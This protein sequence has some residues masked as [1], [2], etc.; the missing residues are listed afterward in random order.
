MTSFEDY[1]PYDSY[2]PNQRR[3]L[4]EAHSVIKGGDH[5]VLMVEA[6]TGTG[7]T[8]ILCSAL[9]AS[10]KTIVVVRTVSQINIY[11]EEM[12]RIHGTGHTLTMGYVV[13]KAKACPLAGEEP[14]TLDMCRRL[15][16]K[17][18]KRMENHL[19][20]GRDPSIEN[21]GMGKAL[22]GLEGLPGEEPGQRTYC[23]YY[24]R[25]IKGVLSGGE[26]A[27]EPSTLA[28]RGA[29]KILEELPNP[30]TLEEALG[31]ACPYECM[32]LASRA[33]DVAILNY[34]HVLNPE[35]AELMLDHQ[36]QVKRGKA[37][38]IVD[39]GHNLGDTVRQFYSSTL[40]TWDLRRAR[41]ELEDLQSAIRKKRG[42]A[43]ALTSEADEAIRAGE[44]M[45][46]TLERFMDSQ[47]RKNSGERRLVDPEF[48]L[49]GLEEAMGPDWEDRISS[50]GL[51]VRE[52]G[53]SQS[54]QGEDEPV[55]GQ[56]ATLVFRLFGTRENERYLVTAM[57]R[58][59]YVELSVS[60]IDPVEGIRSITDQVRATIIMS[61]TLSPLDA[62]E[63]YFFGESGRA[64]KL[65]LPNPFP[66]ANRLL[67]AADR[68]TSRL[69]QRNTPENKDEIRGH[70]RSVVE[71]VPGNVAVFFTA[72]NLMQEYQSYVEEIATGVGKDV[73]VEPQ[74]AEEVPDLLDGFFEGSR[75]GG[76]LLGV[77]GGK[78]AEGIDYWG[79]SLRGVCVVGLPLAP[80]D[81]VQQAINEYYEDKY[82]RRTG[83]LIAYLIPALN[84]AIQASGRVIRGEDEE[85]VMILCD[86]RLAH[87]HHNL[88]PRW[89][90]EEAQ[91]LDAEEST[92]V[93]QGWASQR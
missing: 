2:R 66:P 88:L 28:E 87:T 41:R 21:T 6:P 58:G 73:Y 33:A 20:Q 42:R 86:S 38:L 92:R 8:S 29:K 91:V 89:M 72:Y 90:R 16:E 80:W 23:P 30:D 70:I 4:E 74:D 55:L 39:E 45:L 68:A 82:G 53:L 84:K 5:G 22:D 48:L 31:G 46:S 76:V 63:T 81:D 93:I 52:M 36:L 13:G 54:R 75:R 85:G 27:F 79:D 64:E 40:D 3:M 32:I 50:L 47:Q 12:R 17:S 24:L 10:R 49:W 34:H 65:Q 59:D 57:A 35:I 18:H 11:L 60:N 51:Y 62:Y 69:S 15:R 67:I 25:S 71:H 9:A 37:T 7:K 56:V 44:G 1:F 19:K 83:R 26:A 61:G 14:D 43:R 77:C 78:L